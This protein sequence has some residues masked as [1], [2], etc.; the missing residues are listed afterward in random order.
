MLKQTQVAHNNRTY[1]TTTP[2]PYVQ[3]ENDIYTT[4]DN[5]VAA[6][7][8]A[9]GQDLELPQGYDDDLMT[10][11]EH[12]NDPDLLKQLLIQKEQERQGLSANLDLAARLGLSLHEQIQSL[13]QE[14][15][16][17]IQSLQDQNLALHSKANLSREL[18]LQL[19]HSEHEVKELTG[20]NGFLQKEL[21]S[22]RQEL[23]AFRKELDELSEQMSE[24]S[25]E[26]F[27]AK[28]KVNSYAKR[29]GE[30]E[31]E[32]AATQELNA[33][34]QHQL[35]TALQKQK[36]THTSTTQA[37]KM[38]QSDLG[39][40]FSDGDSMRSTLE[41]LETRQIK[42][43][44]K[45]IE[46]MTNTR[47]Y[48]QL[49][50]EAQ[51]TIHTLRIESDM[52]GHGW[53]SRG[54]HAAIWDNKTGE[55][56]EEHLREIKGDPGIRYL[57]TNNKDRR[58][59]GSKESEATGDLDP[60]FNTRSLEDAATAGTN[61]MELAGYSRG[62]APDHTHGGAGF[63]SLGQ[64]LD[65]HPPFSPVN[66][67]SLAN[68][69]AAAIENGSSYHDIHDYDTVGTSFDTYRDS[70]DLDDP[71]STPISAPQRFSLSADLHQ[72]L[73]ENNILQNVLSGG[74]FGGGGRSR[75]DSGSGGTGNGNGGGRGLGN[76]KPIW[77]APSTIG[78]TGIL[79]SPGAM[80]DI[81]R[82]L[83]SLA[84]QQGSC[85]STISD[86]FS[87][88]PAR[89]TALNN[90]TTTTAAAAAAAVASTEGEL[91]MDTGPTIASSPSP[92]RTVDGRNVLGLKYLLS[93]TSSADLSNVI[94]KTGAAKPPATGHSAVF[95]SSSKDTRARWSMAA[96][97][98]T[99]ATTSTTTT[100]SSGGSGNSTKAQIPS[101]T[102]RS[103]TSSK[104]TSNITMTP[105]K[106]IPI[107]GGGTAS[108]G[109]SGS[110]RGGRKTPSSPAS[111]WSAPSS[112][113]GMTHASRRPSLP[114][115]ASSSSSSSSDSSSSSKPYSPWI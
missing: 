13:E 12:I 56:P 70:I 78:I 2:P 54:T 19:R 79:Y 90:N 108:G 43:E 41:N 99:G 107:A 20:H 14:S 109:S 75:G 16:V 8:G 24:I 48:A 65:D 115:V 29:L 76:A 42:C 83:M 55:N 15:S 97:T 102:S 80:R 52:E 92:R 35:D 114:D 32:L 34:L 68:E 44:G 88:K 33:N 64:E 4:Q 37:V 38:I 25:T 104:T 60:M 93:A 111:S 7:Q 59:Q 95:S 74:R 3:S 18:T 94:T 71:F 86:M 77:T 57:P 62:V 96:T 39:K 66:Q 101:S 73:E 21:D 23:K 26:M 72:R 50:E 103:K 112:L 31:Q 84:N 85:S 46:M 27:D 51:E 11:I 49:L 63:S 5:D 106:P 40:V 69:L 10:Q 36:L 110:A 9:V 113:F 47:E 1:E 67:E 61:S 58:L 105:S 91:T 81:R 98:G 30:V 17:Q 53:S 89:T 22:C 87:P 28:A 6:R 45:V 100:T 82:T